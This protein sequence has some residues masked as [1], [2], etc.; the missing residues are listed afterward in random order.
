[1]IDL[2]NL[3]KFVYISVNDSTNLLDDPPLGMEDKTLESTFRYGSLYASPSR[4][5]VK[6][7]TKFA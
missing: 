5:E 6:L 3:N 2:R 4:A 7:A 1:M